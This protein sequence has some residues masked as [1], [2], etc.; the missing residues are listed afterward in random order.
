MDLRFGRWNVRRV[1]GASSLKTVASEFAK[2]NL[3]LLAVQQVRWDKGGSQPA[4]NF[5]FIYRN[6]IAYQ[7]LRDRIFHRKG[8]Q[9]I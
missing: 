9:V 2:Y 6:G 7:L 4:G 3:D 8:T 1:Y 5:I